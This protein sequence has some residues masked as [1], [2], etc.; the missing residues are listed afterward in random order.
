MDRSDTLV[1]EHVDTE[2]QSLK[3]GADMLSQNPEESTQDTSENAQLA[4]DPVSS[5]D[6]VLSADDQLTYTKALDLKNE[7]NAF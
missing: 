3:C 4:N 1:V 6:H 7:A 5:Q 2:A